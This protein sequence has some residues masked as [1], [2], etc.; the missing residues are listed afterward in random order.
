MRVEVCVQETEVELLCW[1]LMG[2]QLWTMANH[3][4][5]WSSNELRSHHRILNYQRLRTACFAHEKYK[6][7][8]QPYLLKY[9]TEML[10]LRCVVSDITGERGSACRPKYLQQHINRTF[11]WFCVAPHFVKMSTQ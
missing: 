10:L 1:P 2:L 6:G 3:S 11:H 5:L 4:K 9:I 7:V 8:A